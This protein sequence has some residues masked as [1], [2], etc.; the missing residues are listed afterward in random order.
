MI[1]LFK[2]TVMNSLPNYSIKSILDI[3]KCPIFIF[4][5]WNKPKKSEKSD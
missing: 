5:D 3:Y 1:Y 2:E 4:E